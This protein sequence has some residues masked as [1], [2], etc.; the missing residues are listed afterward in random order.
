MGYSISDDQILDAALRAIVEN[1]YHGATI[2]IIAAHAGINQVTLF[3]RFGNKESLVS[4]AVEREARRFDQLQLDKSQD[5]ERDLEAIVRFYQQLMSQRGQ[6]VMS[7]VVESARH[8]EL[9]ALLSSTTSIIT[10]ATEVLTHHQGTGA[11]RSEPVDHTF[12]ALVGPLLSMEMLS[13]MHP[14]V[15]MLDI[16]PRTYVRRFLDGRRPEGLEKA[17]PS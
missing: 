15:M 1:G 10:Q 7:L 11:L 17:P 9:R 2:N 4:A 3:R 8:P 13:T 6:V 16:E 14:E 5:V 12:A